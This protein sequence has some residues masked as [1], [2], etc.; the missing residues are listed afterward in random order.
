MRYTFYKDEET[1]SKLSDY[2]T[3]TNK[4]SMGSECQKFEKKF[5]NFFDMEGSVFFNSGSSANLALIQSLVNLGRLKKGDKVGFSSVTWSTNVMPLLQ[6]GLEPIPIDINLKSLNVGINSLERVF[7]KEYDLKCLF[8]TNLL[9]ISDD[10]PSIRDFCIQK[11]IILL[12]DNCES[13]GSSI[14]EKFLGTYGLASTFSTYIGHHI[15]TIE[16]GFVLTNDQ[17]LL[18]MLKM[19][20]AHGWA[21]SLSAKKRADLKENYAIDD[22]FDLYTFYDLGYNLRPSEINAFIGNLQIDYAKLI[23]KNRMD[24]FKLFKSNL[25]SEVISTIDSD[26]V[27]THSNFAFPL[28]CPNDDTFKKCQSI[29]ARSGIEVRPIVG[30]NISQQP[31]FR[32]YQLRPSTLPSADIVHKLGLYLPNRP[33]LDENEIEIIMSALR[34]ISKIK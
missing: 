3:N 21:R 5:S 32:K 4:F 23:I 20:R 33:D 9:G 22:F 11:N 30:G 13:F 25:T 24:N 2:I 14:G 6:L 27:T 8:I 18:D 29:L 28:I 31:F 19:T 34:Q 1:K 15:S 12:E 16:G 7:S 26:L 10:L 17:E